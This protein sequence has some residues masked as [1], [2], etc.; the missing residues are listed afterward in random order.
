MNGLKQFF[1]AER[2]RVLQPGPFF[3]SKVMARLDEKATRES[4]IWDIIPG[5]TRPVFAVALMLMIGFL[6]AQAFLPQIPQSGLI[7]AYLEAVDE[8]PAYNFLYT[9]DGDDVPT[10]QEFFE[11]MVGLGDDN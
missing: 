4:G 2:K 1:D 5:S 10:E 8:N 3:A 7:E 11:Q 6:F 9:R